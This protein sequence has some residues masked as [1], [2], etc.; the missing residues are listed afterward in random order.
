MVGVL[1]KQLVTNSGSFL[2]CIFLEQLKSQL[3]IAGV[4]LV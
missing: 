3:D 1:M 4:I 2:N